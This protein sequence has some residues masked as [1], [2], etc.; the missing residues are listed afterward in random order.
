MDV[1]LA[2]LNDLTQIKEL[3]HIAVDHMNDE[4]NVSQWTDYNEF[5]KGVI[6]YIENNCFY[7]VERDDEIIGVFAMIYGVDETYNKIKGKWIND[8]EYVTIHKIAVKYYQE[9]IASFIL[10]YVVN[11]IK[12]KFIN[13]IRIDTHKDNISMKTFLKKNGFIYCGVISITN[14]FTDKLSLRN[15][16]L[17]E[18]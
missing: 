15:A 7:V 1:R 9:H 6:K 3:Y 18:F 12:L 2:N 16:Y 4:G 5:E 14:D 17:R 10:N 11:C 8:D 13:N